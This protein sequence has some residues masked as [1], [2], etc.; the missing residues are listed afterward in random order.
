MG[1]RLGW[2]RDCWS[3]FRLFIT[4]LAPVTTRKDLF[5]VFKEAGPVFYVLLPKDRSSGK[6]RGFGFVRFKTEWD[7]NR[8]IQRL[9]GRIVCGR[10][11][12]V[13][14]AK[15]INRDIKYLRAS[16]AGRRFASVAVNPVN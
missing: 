2:I 7:A 16:E 12:G 6:G 4:N 13:Q 15:V 14:I 10:K 9:N 1:A 5:E 8:A 3:L 11:I